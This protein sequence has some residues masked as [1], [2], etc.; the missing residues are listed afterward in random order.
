LRDGLADRTQQRGTL[1]L[2]KRAMK[3]GWIKPWTVPPE[4]AEALPKLVAETVRRAAETG[5]A[6]TVIGG[7]AVL[8]GFLSD[9]VKLA[10]VADK[11]ERLDSNQPTDR[12]RVEVSFVNRINGGDLA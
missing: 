4:E 1:S 10:E 12:P 2:I 9:N 6:R 3:E 11:A 8:R 5:D 7:A